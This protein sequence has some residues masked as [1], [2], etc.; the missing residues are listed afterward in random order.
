M[1]E[2]TVLGVK[3]LQHG[4][5]VLD[6]AGGRA[7][8]SFELLRRY[9]IASTLLEPTERAVLL[10]SHQRKFVRKHPQ[11]QPIQHVAARLDSTLESSAE[12]VALLAGSS[13][14]VGMHADEATEVINS[15]AAGRRFDE[16]VAALY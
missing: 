5:G 1:Q 4:H 12:G 2:S 11:L 10:K 6:V 7:G 9:E 16:I 8:V 14:L 3:A 13:I 15:E